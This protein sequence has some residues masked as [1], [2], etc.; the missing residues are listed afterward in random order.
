MK[1]TP[2]SILLTI[3]A[4]SFALTGCFNNSTTDITD[5]DTIVAT[6]TDTTTD[7]QVAISVDCMDEVIDS[8]LC[9]PVQSE[10]LK[11]I[12]AQV[13][14]QQYQ[15]NYYD[16][17]V[18]FEVDF[19]QPV[20]AEAV[21]S[22]GN[23]TTGAVD[24]TIKTSET[25][26]IEEGVDEADWVKVIDNRYLVTP[27]QPKVDYQY[28]W[29]E[30]SA[31]EKTSCEEQYYNDDYIYLTT[32]DVEESVEVDAPEAVE[33]DSADTEAT[34]ISAKSSPI[35]YHYNWCD[36]RYEL[37]NIEITNGEIKLF[38][39]IEIPA[40]SQLIASTDLNP[41]SNYVQGL[42]DVLDDQAL[43]VLSS[44]SDELPDM[45][46]H[47]GWWN[48]KSGIDLI[49]V[50]NPTDP[51]AKW[52]VQLD[53]HIVDS[54]VLNDELI[55]I[56]RRSPYDVEM[57]S[58]NLDSTATPEQIQNSLLNIPHNKLMG[59]IQ[60]NDK[61]TQLLASVDACLIPKDDRPSWGIN[62]TYITKID[63]NDPSN[64]QTV[65]TLAP[66]HSIYMNQKAIYLLTSDYN[67]M[68]DDDS[69]YKTNLDRFD[70]NTLVFTGSLKVDG[71]L[72]WGNESKFRIKEQTLNDKQVLTLVL[73]EYNNNGTEHFIRN[74]EVTDN[75]FDQLD[76]YP[77]A[78]EA[79]IGKDRE[80]IKSARID[81]TSVQI[82]T[83]LNTD[84]LY[85]FN[86]SDPTNIWMES[87]LEIPGFSTYLHNIED[88]ELTVGLG[89]TDERHLKVELYDQSGTGSSVLGTLEMQSRTYSPATSDYKAFTY[90]DDKDNQLFKIALPIQRWGYTIFDTD[91]L[92]TNMAGLWLIEVDYSQTPAT[93]NV[94][95]DIEMTDQPGDVYQS[96]AVIRGSAVHYTLNGEVYSTQFSNDGTVHTTVVTP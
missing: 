95:N 6:N 77:E 30:N 64:I 67:W 7:D 80:E 41:Y 78:G 60:V 58:N 39:M 24:E 25:N 35:Y 50:S 47:Y 43:L 69:Y 11:W 20:S 87:E 51:Q 44:L 3:S 8:G 4:S 76:V 94:I 89:F 46:S 37:D 90:F 49:D 55:I 92:Y 2:L 48:N 19:A 85:E 96:R 63:L 86:I 31:E 59:T 12:S 42:Y 5:T 1:R 17:D 23:T 13:E 27:K 73:T 93:I 40:S 32:V 88:T 74:F 61:P 45:R 62:F 21:Q 16:F 28:I 65:C 54:R 81:G 33:V 14:L 18:A 70:I 36:G 26:T 75:T 34:G 91:Y 22:E 15:R 29:K 68:S 82:V 83:Y 71:N 9:Q 66:M 10:T 72:G 57:F 56:S 52:S 38:E 84:P 53:G 79:A